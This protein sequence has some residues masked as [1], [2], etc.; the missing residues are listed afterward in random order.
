MMGLMFIGASPGGTGGGVKTTTTAVLLSTIPALAQ[1]R[2]RAVLGRRTIPLETVYRSAAIVVTA[3][4]VTGATA[5]A[6]LATQN[7]TFSSLVFEA[8]S[9]VGTVG[10]TLGATS[11]LD[12]FGRAVVILAMLAGRIGPLTLALLLGRR[13]FHR[14]THPDARILVG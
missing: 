7:G 2:H 12:L 14:H 9:A 8:V 1:G 6:L 10:L 13:T 3:A 11:Q 5:L 4:G